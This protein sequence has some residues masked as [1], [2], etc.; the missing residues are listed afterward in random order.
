MTATYVTSAGAGRPGAP[1]EHS[2]QSS[3]TEAQQ[4]RPSPAAVTRRAGAL[5]P[6]GVVARSSS[7]PVGTGMLVARLSAPSE[8]RQA[9]VSPAG[10]IASSIRD[11]NCETDHLAACKDLAVSVPWKQPRSGT[12]LLPDAAGKSRAHRLR[13]AHTSSPRIL[14]KP[15]PL[16]SG[17][18][19]GTAGL[20]VPGLFKDSMSEAR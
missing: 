10:Q 5:W 12:P 7:R 18:V 13:T 20:L 4:R 11:R 19:S 1:R 2:R 6:A 8:A 9:G 17:Q 14:E 3:V 16:L 15:N